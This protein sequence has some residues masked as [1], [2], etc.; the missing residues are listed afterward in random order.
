M[1]VDF[2][3]KINGIQQGWESLKGYPW[4]VSVR[5]PGTPGQRAPGTPAQGVEDLL[6]SEVPPQVVCAERNW[7]DDQPSRAGS[8]VGR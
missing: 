3:K 1:F 2:L 8:T 6:V 7:L 5:A 4:E